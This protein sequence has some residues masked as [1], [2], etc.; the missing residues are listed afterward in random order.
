[1]TQPEVLEGKSFLF[2]LSVLFPWPRIV[3]DS[4]KLPSEERHLYLQDKINTRLLVL[5]QVG[6]IILHLRKNSPNCKGL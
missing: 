3:T 1:M 6:I 2:A 5:V 4:H